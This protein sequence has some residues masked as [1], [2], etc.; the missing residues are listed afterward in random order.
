MFLIGATRSQKGM[1]VAAN[2]ARIKESLGVAPVTLIAVSKNVSADK[3]AQAF[4]CGVTE[5]G[6]N[7]VQDALEK[8]E[9]VPPHMADKINWHLIGHLQTNKVK[10]VVGKF[11]LI[12][13]VDSLRL[14]QEISDESAKRGLVQPILLQV[15]VLEDPTKSGFSPEELLEQFGTIIA[16]P[17]IKVQGLMTMAPLTDDSSVWQ[18]SFCGLRDLRDQIEKLFGVPL[19]DLSMG[20]SQDWQQAVQCGATMVRLGR[21]IFGDRAA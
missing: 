9:Q 1:S 10:K 14:A 2:I 7:R 19:K 13:S 8:Q 15:K 21:A 11:A 3:I 5:F 18:Q 4:E 6:E 17:G 12:H 16:M 20:M